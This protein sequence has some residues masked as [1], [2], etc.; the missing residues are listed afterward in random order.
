MARGE[1]RVRPEAP[2]MK[3]G[4][5]RARLIELIGEDAAK[6]ASVNELAEVLG[7]S[8]ATIRR[9]LAQLEKDQVISRLYGGAALA[10]PRRELTMAQ[11]QVSNAEAKRAIAQAAVS[12]IHEGDLVI[13]DAGSTAEQIAVAFDNRFEIT[14]VTNGVRCINQLIPQDKVHVL[15]LGG[16]LRGVNET[17][18][19]ADAEMAL[20]RIFGT[21][22]F[23]G[24]D[25]VDAQRGVASRTYDQSRLKS[26][27]LRGAAQ[28]YVI[29][30][31]SKLDDSTDLP[32][33]APLPPAWGL[34]TDSAASNK[35][36]DALE[37]SGAS[38]IVLADKAKE[39][40]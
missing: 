29:A 40:I 1:H 30:D 2:K 11:R 23:I 26:L 18:C 20:S 39:R 19:G 32:Y 21:L 15:V 34:I 3:G 10:L 31:S 17:I 16:N 12:L 6:R 7:V 22:A 4:R 8:V 37:A 25:A 38:T 9:D 36:L 24:A 35:A 33:W 5:R 28:S 27:M 14:V 13:L